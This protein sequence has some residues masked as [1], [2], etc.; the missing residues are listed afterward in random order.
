[1]LV[2][3]LSTILLGLAQ[4]TQINPVRLQ[5]LSQRAPINNY[6]PQYMLPSQMT[7]SSEVI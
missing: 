3:L 7:M 5:Q 2:I 1:M 6:S 4:N